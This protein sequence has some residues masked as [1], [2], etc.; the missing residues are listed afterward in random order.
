MR[1]LF[2]KIITKCF[3]THRFLI[4]PQSPVRE[5]RGED[6]ARD[7]SKVDTVGQSEVHQRLRGLVRVEAEDQ[8]H[9]RASHR[10][11]LEEVLG[12]HVLD[13]AVND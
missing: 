4:V 5:Q 12:E 1:R 6:T 2:R 13:S 10:V 7:H 11:M 3:I 9:L 8:P